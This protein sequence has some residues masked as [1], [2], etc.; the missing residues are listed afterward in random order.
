[1]AFFNLT[2][3]RQRE[4]IQTPTMVL[5]FDMGCY[6]NGEFPKYTLQMSF[7][8]YDDDNPDDYKLIASETEKD[9]Y[10]ALSWAYCKPEDRE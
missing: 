4:V 7:R 5:P 8:G 10:D 3:S 9:I 6:D 2:D 1:M